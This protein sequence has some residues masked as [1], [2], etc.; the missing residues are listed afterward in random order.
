M[1]VRGFLCPC[2]LAVG[3]VKFDRACVKKCEHCERSSGSPLNGWPPKCTSA[4]D[5]NK[6]DGA[7]RR[8]IASLATGRKH[9]VDFVRVPRNLVWDLLNP[10]SSLHRCGLT[11]RPIMV[12]TYA[13][14][15]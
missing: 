9:P 1:L 15:I 7:I 6:T 12:V 3:I 4:D 2:N 5:N 11:T 10:N 8:A 13:S 14:F